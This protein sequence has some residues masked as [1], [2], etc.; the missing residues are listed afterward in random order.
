MDFS[1]F[2]LKYQKREVL[3]I[4]HKATAKPLVSV[5]VQ[6]Y[7]HKNFIRACLDSILQQETEFFFEIIVGE[8]HSSDG[9]REICIYYAQKHPEKIRLLLHHPANKI[10]V[11]N[12]TTGNFNALYNYFSTKGKFIAFCEGDD[13]WTDPSKLQKQVDFLRKE[14]EF[15]LS[16]HSY[17]EVNSWGGLISPSILKQPEQDLD[18]KDL[19]LLKHHPHLST[20]CFR[21]YLQTLPEQ[22][23]EVINMDSFIFS[24]LGAYG[25]GKFLKDIK[26]GNYRYHEQGIWSQKKKTYKLLAKLDTFQKIQCYYIQEKNNPTAHHF[27]LITKGLQKSVIIKYLQS[28]RFTAAFRMAYKLY[29]NT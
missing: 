19:E 5:L 25:K 8:D 23:A 27:R 21:N 17:S 24:L 9:T 7:Q 2:K 26:N 12:T 22:I 28:F 1:Q 18:Q 29:F 10:N 15:V 20:V 6:T 13:L 14:K 11:L 3:H 16:Y 4:P